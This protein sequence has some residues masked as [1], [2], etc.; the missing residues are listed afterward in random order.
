MR[1]MTRYSLFVVYYSLSVCLVLLAS[2][3]ILFAQ[4]PVLQLKEETLSYFKPLKGKIVS[5]A[6]NTVVSDLGVKSGLKKGMRLTIFREGTPFRHPV[7]KE[8]M[9]KVET[10]SGKAEVKDVNEQGSTLDVLK[11]DAKVDDVVRISEMKI[12]VLFYQDKS[13]NWDL[14]DSYYQLLKESGRFDIVDSPLDSADDGKIIAEARK[15]RTDAALLLT[16]KDSDKEVIL[17][18]KILWV[19]DSSKLA[20]SEARVSSV[21][22]KGLRS[23]R[24]VTAPASSAG[25]AILSFDLPFSGRLVTAGDFKGDG[26]Q[27]LVI[28]TSRSLQVYSMGSSLQS[29]YEVKGSAGDDFLWVDAMD[30]NGDGRDE[31]IVTSL[32]GRSVDTVGDSAVPAVKAEGGLVSF[33][34]GLK[35]SE[36]VLLWKADMFLRAVPSLGLI[37]QK[38]DE[39]GGFE[40]PVFRIGYRSGEF[41]TGETIRLPK[42]VNIY[43]FVLVEGPEGVKNTLAYDDSGYLNLYNDNGLRV[44]QSKESYGGFPVSFKKTAPTIMVEKGEWSIKDRLYIRNR[45]SFAVKRTPLANVAK[46][47][48]YKSSDIKALWWTGFSMEE[49]TVIEGISGGIVDYV[50]YADKLIVISKPLFGLKPQNILKGESPLGSMLYVYSVKGK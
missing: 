50:F 16:E 39:G 3:G 22:V 44:W 17:K 32:R 34:Y 24:S 46:G 19:D 37:A 33:I 25:D 42:G 40:G 12:R 23:A 20:E 35:G 15:H 1:R 49:N 30:V 10:P 7:T 29:L 28:G 26:N 21:Y 5:V 41:K 13:A 43:D 18:Q 27:E 31:I 2:R 36:F 38:Y 6:G 4:D 8:P 9:G 11:G 47:L 45:E 14:A 48:G